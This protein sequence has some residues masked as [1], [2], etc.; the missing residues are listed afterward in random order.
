LLARRDVIRI[1]DLHPIV[2]VSMTF[3]ARY[4][5]GRIKAVSRHGV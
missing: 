1:Y 3:R 2:E 5:F 4:C